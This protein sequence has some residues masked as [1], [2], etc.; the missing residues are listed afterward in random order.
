MRRRL[1]LVLA[2]LLVA[3]AA[4]SQWD[5]SKP[6]ASSPASTADV[7]ANW[8]A[9]QQTIGGRNL[10]A[11][12]TFLIWQAGDA[13]V[14]AHWTLSGTGAAIARTGTG[15]GDTNRKVGPYAAKVTSGGGATAT[16]QQLILTTAGYTDHFDGQAVSCGAW[17]RTSSA[18]AVR[19][20]LYDGIGTTYSSYAPNTS[21]WTWATATRTVDNSA[22]Q[23]AFRLEV[24]SGTIAGYLSG[25]TC[26]VGPVPPAYTHPGEGFYLQSPVCFLS[27]NL[28]VGA[29]QCR[30]NTPRPLIIRDA[31]L[32]V[33]TAPA[34]TAILVDLNTWDGAAFTS[35]FTS[36]ARPTVAA[37]AMRGGGQPDTT[38]ARRCMT[39]M[40]G[41]G[42]AAGT[43]LSIDVDQIGTG[44][45]GANMEVRIRYWTFAP[46]LSIF[47]AYNE[48][49]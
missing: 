27:G 47:N 49:N 10:L 21:T 19:F 31:Q 46:P 29:D 24:A 25:P 18:S 16:L 45:V 15:L 34:T 40:S 41:A 20:G 8:L 39:G 48:W 36:G 9:L 42:L 17:M 38:Y 14:P 43:E 23:I 3:T 32:S 1:S 2:L 6:A 4:P 5:P 26:L 11:D 13:A 12:P 28:S 44:T 7:R 30:W 37:T 22:T 35:M 33:R